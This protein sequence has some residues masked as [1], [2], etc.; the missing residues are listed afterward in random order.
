MEVGRFHHNRKRQDPPVVF[1]LFWDRPSGPDRA[2]DPIHLFVEAHD[3]RL[4][5]TNG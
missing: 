3:L 1:P 5:G 4:E 2:H